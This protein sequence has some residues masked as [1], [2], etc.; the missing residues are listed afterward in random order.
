MCVREKEATLFTHYI[1]WLWLAGVVFLIMGFISVRKE[2]DAAAGLDKIIVL[3]RVFAAS[4]LATFG[5]EHFLNV[6]AFSPGVPSWIPFH[7]F[8]IV[9][10]GAALFA[11]ALSLSWNRY[12]RLSSTLLAIM[13]FI[14]VLTLHI[15]RV[16]ASHD[17]I[18]WAVVLR[19]T[20]FAGGFLAFAGSLAPRSKPLII[21]GRLVNAAAFLFF[22]VMHILHPQNAPGVPLGKLTP[23]WMP[24]P[25]VLATITALFLLAA[26]I[27]ILIDRYARTATAWLGLWMVYLTLVLY[28]PILLTATGGMELIEGVNYV[29]D[30]LLFAGTILLL[31]SALPQ[32][33]A[34]QLRLEKRAERHVTT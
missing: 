30:T 25:H 34:L 19:D 16:V 17:R 4:A 27:A 15:P 26:G 28:L 18:S 29:F 10:V 24:W 22:A 8:W 31:T 6:R 21:I 14:F 33:H 13:L 5:T 9:F 12:T 32:N 3:G 23:A 11:G 1:F 2:F 20:A 7:P